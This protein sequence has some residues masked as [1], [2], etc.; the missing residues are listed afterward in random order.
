MNGIR[1][2]IKTIGQL[3]LMTAILYLNNLCV[4]LMLLMMAKKLAKTYIY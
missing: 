1:I 2:T 3:N 4:F